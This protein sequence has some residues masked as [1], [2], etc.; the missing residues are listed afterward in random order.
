MTVRE[1]CHNR[2]VNVYLVEMGIR[3][4]LVF[5]ILE[6]SFPFDSPPHL[7]SMGLKSN[8]MYNDNREEERK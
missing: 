4:I 3:T 5:V 7:L 1:S 2:N 8:T 6:S